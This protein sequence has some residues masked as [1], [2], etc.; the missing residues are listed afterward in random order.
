MTAEVREIAATDPILNALDPMFL[1]AGKIW[2][3]FFNGDLVVVWGVVPASLLSDSAYIWSWTTPKVLKCRKS[4]VK[5]SKIAVAKMLGEYPIL[6]GLCEKETHWL[7][8]LGATIVGQDGKY[9]TFTI[10]A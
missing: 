5:L 1:G 6:V 4:F 10:K 7:Q 9:L 3:G 2:A 8:W